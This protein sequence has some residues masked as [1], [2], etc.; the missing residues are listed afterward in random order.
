MKCHF[1]IGAKVPHHRRENAPLPLGPRFLH[2]TGWVGDSDWITCR[3]SHSSSNRAAQIQSVE[4][5][6][7]STLV[8]SRDGG[9][10]EKV[11]PKETLGDYYQKAGE[12]GSVL[13]VATVTGS[14]GWGASRFPMRAAKLRS[15]LHP[16]FQRWC[17]LNFKSSSKFPRP[18]ATLFNTAPSWIYPYICQLIGSAAQHRAL[19]EHFPNRLGGP[20]VP[21]WQHHPSCYQQDFSFFF[22]PLSLTGLL[23]GRRAFAFVPSPAHHLG[24]LY[25]RGG[26]RNLEK[27]SLPAAKGDPRSPSTIYS[28][29]PFN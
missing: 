21:S 24:D 26:A 18:S 29:R 28:W 11:F 27:S 13:E 8:G 15:S 14:Q 23:G 19:G 17:P 1:K 16:Q 4:N 10:W 9:S 3:S 7:R 12:K 22:L 20:P 2:V 6:P 25:R 5:C